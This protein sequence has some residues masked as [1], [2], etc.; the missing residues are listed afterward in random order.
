ML[1][2]SVMNN[3][4]MQ[5][6]GTWCLLAALACL[7]FSVFARDLTPKEIYERCYIRMVR[8]V[9]PVNDPNLAKVEAGS[10]APDKACLG[11]FDLAAFNSSGVMVKRTDVTAKRILK[12][13]HDLHQSW[14]SVKTNADNRSANY[15]IRDGEEGA[16]Y[17]T[18]AAFLP[19]TAFST[20][21][22]LNSGLA[23]VRDQVSYPHEEK[24][25]LT[26]RM[27]TYNPAFPYA[28][29]TD[30]ILSYNGADW[31]AKN[32]KLINVG[33]RALRVGD[34]G[35]AETGSLVGVK[36]APSL[37][38]PF[39]RLPF[40]LPKDL[41]SEMAVALLAS[42]N[43]FQV[44]AHFGGGILGSQNFI[45]NNVNTNLNALPNGYAIINRRLTSKI[46]EDLMCHQMPSLDDADITAE[47]KPTSTFTFQQTS[48]CM[49]CH[50]SMDG[51]A[52]VYRNIFTYVSSAN[53]NVGTQEIGVNASG[54]AALPYKSSNATFA[55]QPPTG[56]LHYR[57]LVTR[58]V[59]KTSL[60]SIANLGSQ[61]A[62]GNDIYTCAAK[63]YYAF[64]TGI[65]V[66][67]KSTAVSSEDKYH[68]DIVV[69]LGKKLKSTQSVRS[70]L[71]DLFASKPFQSSDYQWEG[72]K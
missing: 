17:F 65:D 6:K 62:S 69:A 15:I 51:A 45:L 32:Q 24:N 55:L 56:T 5:G 36:A 44:N 49:R 63:R 53:A 27:V 7:S 3:S 67:L 61:L 50:S 64:F 1:L 37:K 16:L 34:A 70:M 14:L 72:R 12:T 19:N 11:L 25:F 8:A 40:T 52:F 26:Q 38:L 35:L 4:L 47:I 46:F 60:S 9:P 23:G 20:V 59:V 10:L 58:K 18:R 68:Q 29:E 48:S 39:F 30:F 28:G 42:Y 57:E 13:F 31:D 22:T 41:T 33:V 66:G 54:A 21:V 2:K 43:N 71:L